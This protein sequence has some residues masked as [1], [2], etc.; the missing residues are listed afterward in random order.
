MYCF[1]NTLSSVY[2]FISADIPNTRSG[3]VSR[4]VQ[5]RRA[6]ILFSNDLIVFATISVSSRS[7]TIDKHLIFSIPKH[8]PYNPRGTEKHQKQGNFF[9]LLG[10][11]TKCTSSSPNTTTAVYK[12]EK[13]FIE[14]RGMKIDQQRLLGSRDVAGIG[15]WFKLATNRGGNCLKNSERTAPLAVL[16]DMVDAYLV[17]GEYEILV[18]HC[19]SF[20]RS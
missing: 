11:A 1:S 5:P 7:N 3:S 14:A 20:Q 2:L 4:A 16:R 6:S 13:K 19:Y 15:A 9:C 17:V 12:N 18:L 10:I 8:E